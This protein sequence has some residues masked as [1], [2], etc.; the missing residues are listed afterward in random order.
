MVWYIP[1]LNKVDNLDKQ[2]KLIKENPLGILVTST[3][4]YL[5]TGTETEIS[6]LPFIIEERGDKLIL[7]T[8]MAKGNDQLKQLQNLNEV[9]VLFRSTFDSYIS[10]SWYLRKEIDHKIVSTWDYS[11]V[12]VKG[13][14]TIIAEKDKILEIVTKIT[15]EQEAKRKVPEEK[16][17]KVSEAPE[18]YIDGM[19]GAI[20]GLEIEI[21]EI[22]GKFKLNQDHTKKE[23][24]NLVKNYK[25]ELGGDL[26]E[27]MAEITIENHPSTTATTTE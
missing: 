17:W 11:A 7:I 14:P 18:R 22:K 21:T 4:G 5:S 16:R 13:K 10:A 9:I 25:E 3:S 6:H 26:G 12:H 15:A 27:K 8:H 2:V 23:L 19:L 20:Y 1:K 24:D